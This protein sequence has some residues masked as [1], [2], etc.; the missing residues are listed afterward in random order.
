MDVSALGKAADSEKPTHIAERPLEADGEGGG[1]GDLQ[2]LSTNVSHSLKKTSDG[3]TVLI[4][5]PSDSPDDPLNWS[6]VR[7]STS[8]HHDGCE[9]R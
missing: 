4:P 8:A 7:L 3:V 5:Q 1:D 2:V 9:R 6:F